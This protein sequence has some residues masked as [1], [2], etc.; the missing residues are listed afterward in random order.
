M[1]HQHPIF[2]DYYYNDETHEIY[3]EYLDK[4]IIPTKHH[5]GYMVFIAEDFI[6][7]TK[8]SIKEMSMDEMK[9]KLN[10]KIAEFALKMAKSSEEKKEKELKY[11]I[12]PLFE[13]ETMKN[14]KK[15]INSL[16]AIITNRNVDIAK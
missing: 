12:N 11:S 16:D 10:S 5:S 6:E 3:C 13:A 8:N 4:V 2:D 15:E 9:E 1:L 14:K 7:K